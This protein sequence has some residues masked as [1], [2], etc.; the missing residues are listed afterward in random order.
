MIYKYI[1]I[2]HADHLCAVYALYCVYKSRTPRPYDPRR[3]TYRV[4][5]RGTRRRQKRKRLCSDVAAG[6]RS[7]RGTGTAHCFWGAKTFAREN[8]PDTVHIIRGKKLKPSRIY[9][10]LWGG[11]GSARQRRRGR[12]NAGHEIRGPI[13]LLCCP[14]LVSCDET[15]TKTRDGVVRRR[16]RIFLALT[17]PFVYAARCR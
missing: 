10:T 14:S 13:I 2:I 1:I 12:E 7:R 8:K 9:M 17:P 16:Q 3:D 11:G 6:G 5:Y 4:F 15:E